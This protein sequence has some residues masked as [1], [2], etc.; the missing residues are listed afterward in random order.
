MNRLIF[1]VPKSIRD[2]LVYQSEAEERSMA[3]VVIEAIKKSDGYKD[4][5]Y[6]LKKAEVEAEYRK[7]LNRNG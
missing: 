2:Y 3:A 1:T 6:N 4:W 7:V 5:S